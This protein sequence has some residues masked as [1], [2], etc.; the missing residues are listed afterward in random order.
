MNIV[1]ILNWRYATKKMN[2]EKVAPEK[3]EKILNAIRLTASSGGLQPYK[4]I[5]VSDP[6][7]KQKIRAVG[8]DQSQLT[9]CSEILIFAAWDK[10][11]PERVDA[12]INNMAEERSIDV[13]SLEPVRSMFA[14]IQAASDAEAFAW[15][16]KQAYIALGTGLIAAAAEE[17][18][19]TP[20]E[21]FIN[22]DLDKLLDLES[23]GLK[24]AAILTLGYRDT[25]NDWLVSMK[26]VRTSAEDFFIKL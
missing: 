9:D 1:D 22:A 15:T 16:S 5:V 18:D 12:F 4:V 7:L 20:M 11:T 17:V 8:Y 10:V 23:K 3:V 14:G 21:G 25:E 13:S 19:A 24:S 6:D 2:G 26:K